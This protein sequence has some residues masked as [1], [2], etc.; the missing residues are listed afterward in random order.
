MAVILEYTFFQLCSNTEKISKI[1]KIQK[2]PYLNRPGVDLIKVT[3]FL[4]CAVQSGHA[5]F[6]AAFGE[7]LPDDSA[8]AYPSSNV[9][10]SKVGKQAK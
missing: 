8:F 3:L 1:Y 2:K 6:F 7:K 4:M 9:V 5:P 10:N